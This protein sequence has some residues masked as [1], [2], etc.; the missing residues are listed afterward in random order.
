MS[1]YFNGKKTD[2]KIICREAEQ[3]VQRQEHFEEVEGGYKLRDYAYYGAPTITDESYFTAYCGIDKTEIVEVGVQSFGKSSVKSL[4]LP[5]AI[6]FSNGAFGYCVE[7]KT[8]SLSALTEIRR[9]LFANSSIET[10]NIPAVSV[11]A[12]A[13]ALGLGSLKTVNLGCLDAAITSAFR[14]ATALE[15]ITI[16]QG[17]TANLYLQ[18]S[19]LYSQETLHALIDNLADMTGQEA[20]YFSVGETN[21]AKISAEYITKLQNK[22]WVYS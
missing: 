16:G 15:N 11:I 21:L 1:I 13:N 9:V 14:G 4:D 8:L 19:E 7:L 20:P 2:L 18:Y 22:N 5:S 10:L 17:T 3:A 6:T 12:V